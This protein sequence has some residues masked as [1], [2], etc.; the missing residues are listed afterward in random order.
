MIGEKIINYRIISLIGEGGMGSVYLGKH[1]TL[2]RNVAIKV[3]LPEF[4]RNPEI[5]E[6]FINEAKTLSKLNH[7]NIVTLYDFTEQ[8]NNLFLI[9]EYVEGNGIDVVVN[10]IT[11]PIPLQRCID[12]FTKILSGFEYAHS[13]GIVHRDIKPSNIILKTD[14]TPKI[15]DFGIAKII[16]GDSKL[17]KTGTRMGSVLYMSPEQVLGKEIDYR[18][19]IYSLGVTLFEM[20]T[21]KV[22]YDTTTNSEYEI[23]NK[24]VNEQLP[25]VLSIIPHIT[26]E[27]DN[28]ISVATAKNS[29][30]RYQTC[31]QFNHALQNL[32]QKN[33]ITKPTIPNQDT[34]RT[35]LV[36]KTQPINRPVQNNY[37]IQTPD[38]GKKTWVWILSISSV[39]LVAII[40]TFILLNDYTE[41]TS[42]GK[43]TEPKKNENKVTP[44]RQPNNEDKDKANIKNTVETWLN[45]WQRKD[46]SCLSSYMTEDY[47][48][49]TATGKNKYQDKPERIS[50]WQT[51]F[52]ERKYISVT[53]SDFQV[54]VTGGNATVSYYQTYKSDKFNDAG[55]K[56][57]YLRKE[58]EMWRI[59]KD[60]FY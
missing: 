19:D 44:E 22:P 43:I 16:Q 45:C 9:M 17:T 53:H 59:Y 58:N 51:Q 37:N 26:P 48:Y 11:G 39:I 1:E 2:D 29:S 20:L 27:I 28:I 7:Q 12:I 40:I 6:R 31:K 32:K 56:I 33:Y 15:L 38:N 3:L 50:V 14:D 13:Q 18:S 34:S 52:S 42:N 30:D 36:N 41:T 55:N 35:K 25:P 46:I 4:A 23:Q 49:E 47:Q 60:S 5:R 54:Q 21:G 24:I 57:L 8:G 10:N